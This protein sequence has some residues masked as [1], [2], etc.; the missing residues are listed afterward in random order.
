MSKQLE[1]K[2]WRIAIWSMSSSPLLRSVIRKSAKAAQEI[3][4]PDPAKTVLLVAFCGLI[5]GSL[6]SY[7]VFAITIH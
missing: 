1:I 2:F 7:L 5:S 6:L 4:I 3:V